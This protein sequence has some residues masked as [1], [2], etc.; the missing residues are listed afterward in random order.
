MLL[1]GTSVREKSIYCGLILDR[2]GPK[3]SCEEHKMLAIMLQFEQM[4]QKAVKANNSP[5][6]LC[7]DGNVRDSEKHEF[8]DSEFEEEE[9]VR[10]GGVELSRAGFAKEAQ[11]AGKLDL[12]KT[13]VLFLREERVWWMSWMQW[14]RPRLADAITEDTSRRRRFSETFPCMFQTTVV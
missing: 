8:S 3:I 9:E 6:T 14:Q 1:S 4:E 10:E 12:T 13:K 5:S 7:A 11:G 2:K